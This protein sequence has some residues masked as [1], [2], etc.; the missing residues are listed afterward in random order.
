LISNQSSDCSGLPTGE[1]RSIQIRLDGNGSSALPKL[2]SKLSPHPTQLSAYHSPYVDSISAFFLWFD[3]IKKA[4]QDKS[5]S[6][7]QIEMLEKAK[8]A[9]A[10]FQEHIK[11]IEKFVR[12]IE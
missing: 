7:A 6:D 10:H 2:A 8:N 12:S 3:E 9:I 1:H 5:L 11:E 4:A